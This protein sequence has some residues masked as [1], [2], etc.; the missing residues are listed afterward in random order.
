[1]GVNNLSCKKL[2]GNYIRD[3]TCKVLHAVPGTQWVNKS[4]LWH[5]KCSK[6]PKQSHYL[7]LNSFLRHLYSPSTASTHSSVSI[8]SLTPP[9]PLQTPPPSSPLTYLVHS[10]PPTDST[11]LVSANS[12]PWPPLPH[13]LNLYPLVFPLI[14]YHKHYTIP[15]LHY[16]HFPLPFHGL[17]L[18]SWPL[19]TLK[20]KHKHLKIHS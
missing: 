20:A 15:S 18:A 13:P 7:F 16:D 11:T 3:N 5:V 17:F 12:S 6:P 9:L 8:K 4:E 2:V 10:P 1:M 14:S 19:Q